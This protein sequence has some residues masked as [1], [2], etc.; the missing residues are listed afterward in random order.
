MNEQSSFCAC[1]NGYN[2]YKGAYRSLQELTMV[3]KELLRM[4][5]VSAHTYHTPQ[6]IA[7]ALALPATPYIS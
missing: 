3:T 2:G 5:Q 1:T 6:S 4:N 7:T